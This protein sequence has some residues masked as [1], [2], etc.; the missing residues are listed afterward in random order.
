[1]HHNFDNWL[2]IW[3]IYKIVYKIFTNILLIREGDINSLLLLFP[4]DNKDELPVREHPTRGI[5]VKDLS[6]HRVQNTEDILDLF[7]RGKQE[8]I[9]AETRM[10]RHSSR[11]HSIFQISIERR[12]D[13]SKKN[14]LIKVRTPRTY[15]HDFL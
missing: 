9:T 4:S 2:K 3:Q 12:L 14:E 5:Y 15:M 8:L 6:H 11:S 7:R 10:V 13:V 1:M